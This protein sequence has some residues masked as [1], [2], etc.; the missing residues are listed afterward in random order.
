MHV[1]S[2]CPQPQESVVVAIERFSWLRIVNAQPNAANAMHNGNAFMD[3]TQ[4]AHQRGW[5][6]RR[7]GWP[8]WKRRVRCAIWVARGGPGCELPTIELVLPFRSVGGVRQFRLRFGIGPVSEKNRIRKA[9][10][11]RCVACQNRQWAFWG[12]CTLSDLRSG[13]GP[14]LGPFVPV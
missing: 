1:R 12:S 4:Q 3:N 7:R 8:C 5:G 10:A 9:G 6:L 11:K 2:T 13:R 14:V